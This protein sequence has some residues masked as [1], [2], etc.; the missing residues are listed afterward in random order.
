MAKDIQMHG[1]ATPDPVTYEFTGMANPNNICL[2]AGSETMLKVGPDG[3][4]IRGV[5]VPQDE[6]EAAAVYECFREWLTWSQ[7]NR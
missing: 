3:F 6:K 7:L 5:K 4:W 2:N 1:P